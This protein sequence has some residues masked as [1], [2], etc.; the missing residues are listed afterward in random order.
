[1]AEDVLAEIRRLGRKTVFL[2]DGVPVFR[3]TIGRELGELAVFAPPHLSRQRAAAVAAR[4][5]ELFREGK[6]V[7]AAAEAP[8]Y[9]RV[10]QAERERKIRLEAQDH[11]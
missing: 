10:S 11:A 6:T 3:E 5:L 4:G 2:G 1:M 8:E 9:Y 7:D